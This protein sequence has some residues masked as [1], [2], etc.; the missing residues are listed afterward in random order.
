MVAVTYDAIND[1]LYWAKKG[2][3]AFVSSPRYT[4]PIR[5]S[6]T[7]TLDKAV[8]IM[9]VVNMHTV[10]AHACIL[11]CNMQAGWGRKTGSSRNVGCA[12]FIFMCRANLLGKDENL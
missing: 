6:G 8:V 12:R 5:V 4:G 10:T 9:E 3:G 7:D 1:E 2:S 11:V